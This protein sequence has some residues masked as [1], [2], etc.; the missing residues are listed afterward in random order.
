MALFPSAKSLDIKDYRSTFYY[1]DPLIKKKKTE[2]HL[3][4]YAAFFPSVDDVFVKRLEVAA[5]G[6]L[7]DKSCLSFP[8]ALKLKGTSPCDDQ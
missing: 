2:I 6:F 8:A 5:H 7:R 4:T 3:Q 1:L